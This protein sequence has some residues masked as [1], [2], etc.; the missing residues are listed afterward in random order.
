MAETKNGAPISYIDRSKILPPYSLDTDFYQRIRAAKPQNRLAAEF[1]ISPFS[2]K[3]FIVKKGQ[4]FR[5]I[6]SSGPQVGTLTVWNAANTRERLDA[7][8]TWLAAGSIYSTVNKRL[9]SR[10]PWFVPMATCIENTVIEQ[11]TEKQYHHHWLGTHCHPQLIEM[12]TGHRCANSCHENLRQAVSSFGVEDSD[13]Y[14]SVSLFQKFY[15]DPKNAKQLHVLRS[16]AKA[17]DY[18]TYYAEIDLLV[19]VSVCPYGDGLDYHGIDDG[20]IQP[21]GVEI[22]DT[23]IEPREFPK[24]TDWRRS[25][26]PDRQGSM[27]FEIDS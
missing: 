2:G 3:A 17:G 25:W 24:R 4:T 8:Y 12:R 21:L 23:D 5:I 18:V 6:E 9:W 16:D 7:M 20:L 22:H 14:N 1:S 15:L 10:M 13:I 27:S 26:T 11:S 19:A